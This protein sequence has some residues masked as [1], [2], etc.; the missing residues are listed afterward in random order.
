MDEDKNLDKED[1]EMESDRDKGPRTDMTPRRSERLAEP[2]QKPVDVR[3]VLQSRRFLP[4]V[5]GAGGSRTPDEYE[6][7][8]SMEQVVWWAHNTTG[9]L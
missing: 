4:R 6:T 1:E 5:G 3:K 9:T 2:E 8:G 7:S